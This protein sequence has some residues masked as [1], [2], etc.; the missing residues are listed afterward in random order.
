MNRKRILHSQSFVIYFRFRVFL[1]EFSSLQIN[2]KKLWHAINY[3]IFSNVCVYVKECVCV[4]VCLSECVSFVVSTQ[5]QE[6][7]SNQNMWRLPQP[8]CSGISI[9]NN[10]N[11]KVDFNGSVVTTTYFYYFLSLCRSFF[12]IKVQFELKFN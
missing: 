4:R 5:W 8:S 6:L 7:K 3:S 10:N 12:H 2:S 1:G 11:I 9:F